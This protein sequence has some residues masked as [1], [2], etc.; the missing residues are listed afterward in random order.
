MNRTIWKISEG[1][2][3]HESQVNGI[4][5]KINKEINVSVHTIYAKTILRGW[6]RPFF[7]YF[8]R[9]NSFKL[10]KFIIDYC[11]KYKNLSVNLPPPDLIISSGGSSVLGSRI[12]ST[13]YKIPYCFVGERKPFSSCWFDF[14]IT[15]VKS[16]LGKN[17]IFVELIPTHLKLDYEKKVYS[18]NLMLCA[19][20]IGG[21]SRSHKYNDNDWNSLSKYMNY[22]SKR[23]NIKWLLSTSRRTSQKAESFLKNNILDN[24]L[25]DPIW[26]NSNAYD[27]LYNHLENAEFIFV[28]Q[29][30][31][32]MITEAISFK[33]PV[34]IIEPSKCIKKK[35]SFIW[36]YYERL[37]EQ[38]K[39]MRYSIKNLKNF[40]FD[41]TAFNTKPDK[42]IDYAVKELLIRLKWNNQ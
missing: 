26:F 29:D 2:P 5:D 38:K 35:N 33:K 40:K 6:I 28:T 7:Y 23:N 4:V 25:L 31:L 12:L 8:V 34:V 24:S 14:V 10:P 18:N 37:I 19:M 3:G 39:V 9:K 30:S 16:E 20:I 13:K 22:I 17:S 41:K 11:I 42:S 36:A 21:D 27:S 32:S 1:S 15:P